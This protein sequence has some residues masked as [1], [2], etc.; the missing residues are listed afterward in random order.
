M[1]KSKRIEYRYSTTNIFNIY[2]V[3]TRSY[4]H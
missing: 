1:Q 2:I 3:T 4:H